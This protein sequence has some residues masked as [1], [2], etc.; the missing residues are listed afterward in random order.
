MCFGAQGQDIA[1]IPAKHGHG[2]VRGDRECGEGQGDREQGAAEDVLPAHWPPRQP[3]RGELPETA[4]GA[5][6]SPISK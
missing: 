3:E 2:L 5:D 1:D 4:G 6:Q